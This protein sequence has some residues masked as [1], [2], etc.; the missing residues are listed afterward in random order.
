MKDDYYKNNFINDYKDN[1]TKIIDKDYFIYKDPVLGKKDVLYYNN[2]NVSIGSYGNIVDSL[3]STLTSYELEKLRLLAMFV[4]QQGINNISSTDLISIYRIAIDP[5]YDDTIRNLGARINAIKGNTPNPVSVPVTPPIQPIISIDKTN[6]DITIETP[7]KE[8]P[9]RANPIVERFLNDIRSKQ[10]N[11]SFRGWMLPNGELLSQ[12]VDDS[13]GRITRL[14][15]DHARLYKIFMAGVEKYDKVSFD[16]INDLYD[17]YKRNHGVG[18]TG[19]YDWDE[20]FAVEALGWMQIS[21]NGGNKI[22]YRGER[23][24]D[25]LIRPFLVDYGFGFDISDFGDVYYVE[26]MHLY[27]HIDEILSLGLEEKYTRH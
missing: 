9:K 27:D 21:V 22:L 4:K 3:V 25:R 23:W 19:V 14:R 7:K 26:F 10:G 16:K 20:S 13:N 1:Y 6:S 2:D 24:Q 12:Y 5:I 17:K 15:Q 18:S 11:S 8:E